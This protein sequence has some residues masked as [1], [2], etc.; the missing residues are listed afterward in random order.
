MR[1]W[2]PCGDPGVRASGE[3]T[4]FFSRPPLVE[5]YSH[6][7]IFTEFVMSFFGVVSTVLGCNSLV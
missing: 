6:A 2:S 4:R 7:F 1:S 5:L 3:K